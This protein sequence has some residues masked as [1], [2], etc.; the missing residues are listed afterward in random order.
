MKRVVCIAATLM[1]LCGLGLAAQ[2]KN[3]DYELQV[4][5]RLEGQVAPGDDGMAVDLGSTALYT[6]FECSVSEPVRR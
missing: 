4:I 3:F 1:A 5:S 6:H 2:E